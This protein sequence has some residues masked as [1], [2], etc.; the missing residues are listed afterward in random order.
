MAKVKVCRQ[1]VDEENQLSWVVSEIEE[2]DLRDGELP[3]IEPP[4][5]TIPNS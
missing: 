4:V 5:F 3:Y 1:E 2:E